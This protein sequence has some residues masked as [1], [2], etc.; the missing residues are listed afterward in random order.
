MSKQSL[1]ESQAFQ[2][3]FLSGMIWVL[4]FL[5]V[6][7]IVTMVVVPLNDST[8]A[9]YAEIARIMVETQNWVTPM[10]HYHDPFWAKPPL[11][12]WLS[13]ISMTIFGISPFAARLPAL[14]LSIGI[15]M[16][17]WAVA[18]VRSGTQTAMI[19]TVILAGSFYFYLDAGTVMTDPS[20]LLCTT[21]MMVSFWRSVVWQQRAWAY[22]FF[23]AMALGLL[24]KGLVALVLMGMPLGLWVIVE[25]QWL[26]I[27]QRM[28]W[29][30]GSLLLMAIAFPWYYLAEKRTPGFLN[31]FIIGEHVQRFLQPGWQGDKY[32]VAHHAPL[33]MI[34]VYALMGFLP[35][36]IPG[37]IWIGYNF[38]RLRSL[39]RDDDGWLRYLLFCTFTPLLFFTFARN[40]IYPYV[41]PSLP[42]FALL[43]AEFVKRSDVDLKYVKCFVPLAG[44]FG[45]VFLLG[46]LVFVYQPEWIAKSQDR[47]V[48]AVAHQHPEQHSEFV[49]WQHKIDYSAQFY[50]AGRAIATLDP[51]VLCQRISQPVRS[52]V[53][54]DSEDPHPM[55]PKILAHLH[56]VDSINVL[57]KQ[58]HIYQTDP[59]VNYCNA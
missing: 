54:I 34:W 55:P 31:Y 49:Y 35:W 57:S 50:S 27:W 8:E 24:A 20:L 52:Y 7:R 22:V 17:V 46:A 36:C 14:L 28:P 48:A 51:Q 30:F 10:H 38:K 26:A 9:R 33:G 45:W 39:S 42:A 23:I 40:I 59:G 32:G 53:V 3:K 21:L 47:V 6:V 44:C 15:L 12:T 1:Y 5:T 41:F 43:F 11:S 58:F 25:K 37:L 16:V 13:A 56:E 18:R 19:A 2:Q 29:I 4:L